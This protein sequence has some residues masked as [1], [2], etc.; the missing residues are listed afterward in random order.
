MKSPISIPKLIVEDSKTFGIKFGQSYFSSFSPQPFLFRWAKWPILIP[1]LILEDY[2][3]FGI[4]VSGSYFRDYFFV[5]ATYFHKGEAAY[6][7]RRQQPLKVGLE[8]QYR[9]GRLVSYWKASIVLEG[10]YC[11]ERLV[12]YWKV[13]IVLE[14]QYRIGRLVS[15]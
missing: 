3:K 15:Y 13:S 14:G 9:I 4:K 1:I 11:I 5:S 2:K 8:G 12:S 7:G 6:T 10:Q